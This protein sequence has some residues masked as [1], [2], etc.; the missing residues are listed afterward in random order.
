[1]VSRDYTKEV[2]LGAV[3]RKVPWPLAVG[4]CGACLAGAVW[5][6]VRF[7]PPAPVEAEAPPPAKAI[8]HR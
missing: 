1:M 7:A 2:G 4:I 8:A 5:A 6:A 3:D